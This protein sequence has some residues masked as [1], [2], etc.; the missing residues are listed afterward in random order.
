M[1]HRWRHRRLL[2]ALALAASASLAIALVPRPPLAHALTHTN[3]SYFCG[4]NPDNGNHC[5][6]VVRWTRPSS[7]SST[8]IYVRPLS[9]GDGFVTNEMWLGGGPPPNL[10]CPNRSDGSGGGDCWI[11]TGVT[12]GY[13][14]QQAYTTCTQSC[15]YWAD[16]RPSAPGT[17]DNYNEHFL[18]Y[19]PQSDYNTS[20]TFRIVLATD[21]SG[22]YDIQVFDRGCYAR[23]DYADVSTQDQLQPATIDI[24]A[25]VAGSSGASSPP[26]EYTDNQFQDNNGWHYEIDGGNDISGLI[27]TPPV[28]HRWDRTP[29]TDGYLPISGPGQ[30]YR[31]GDWYTQFP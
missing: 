12:I 18:G 14:A 9:A 30:T 4:G 10:I 1:V 26:A 24:G 6:G 27:G 13:L 20:V 19:A 7:G 3:A 8:N 29:T 22:R 21:G 16:E 2:L 31:G 25:E 23:P 5:Y 15:Y 17:T 11:E 28:P